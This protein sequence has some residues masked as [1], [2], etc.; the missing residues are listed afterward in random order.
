MFATNHISYPRSPREI[1]HLHDSEGSGHGVFSKADAV[2]II[3]KAWGEKHPLSGMALGI[4]ES[5]LI[6][7]APRNEE[8]IKVVEMLARAAARHGLEGEHLL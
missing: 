2:L 3:Q 1:F 5:Y 4:P 8:E 7:Y 6:I